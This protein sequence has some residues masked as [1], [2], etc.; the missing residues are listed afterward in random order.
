MCAIAAAREEPPADSRMSAK[1]PCTL[2]M[3]STISSTPSRCR[4]RSGRLTTAVTCAPDRA[5]IWVARCP[6]PPAAPVIKTRLPSSGAPWRNARNAV[7]P[8]TGNAAASSKRTLSRNTAIRCPGTAARCAQPALSVSATTRAPALGPLPSAAGLTTAPLMSWPGRQPS[9]RVWKSRNSPRLSENARTSTSASFGA[10]RGSGTSRSSTGAGP[11]GVFTT[12]SIVGC[13]FCSSWPGVTRPS[14]K[15]H[16][17]PGSSPGDDVNRRAAGRSTSVQPQIGDV[18]RVGL[19]FT[20]LDALDDVSQHRVG[21]RREADL[22]ALAHDKAV[23]ILDLGP[24]ALAHVLAHR[25]AMLAAASADFGQP[26]VVIGLA[27]LGVA[28]AGA[29][30]R[31]GRQVHDFLELVAERLADADC[32]AAEPRREIADRVVADHVLADHAGAGREP[33]AHHVRDE[34]RPA[35]APQILGYHGAVGIADQP[36]DLAGASGYAAVHFAGA[37]HRVAR[38]RFAGGAADLARRVQFD[39]NRAGNAAHRLAPADDAGDGLLVH[40]VLQ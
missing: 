30:N 31:I 16:E 38:T 11:L 10:G 18:P 39:G 2:S 5:A 33:V 7:N 20:A 3:P 37:E 22:F 40:A 26:V 32:F 36:A 27:R 4:P 15:L 8:A 6:T 35:L 25:R 17:I 12:A 34:L 14:T 21:R 29:R 23:Q 24:A 1:R 13:S 9:G 19:Q 28:L